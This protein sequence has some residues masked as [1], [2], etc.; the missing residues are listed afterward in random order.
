MENAKSLN[1]PI[2]PQPDD[3]TCG[4]T[5]LHAIYTFFKDSIS[6]D[7]VIRQTK[8]LDAG[9]TL[10]VFLACNA[11]QRGYNVTI[12]TYNLQLFDPT[13]FERKGTDLRH[14]LTEQSKVKSDP[15]LDLATGGYLEFL[16]LGGLLRYVDLTPRLLRR[17]LKQSIPILTGLSATYLYRSPRE[18][19]DCKYNDIAG[20]PVGHFVILAGY[21]KA[22]RLVTVVDPAT[23]NPIADEH[24]YQVSVDR[25]CGAIL[26]GALT[27]DANMVLIQPKSTKNK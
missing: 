26:L 14:K 11:L 20:D 18:T 9:G 16:K 7:D 15:K 24:Y 12:Y 25:I 3:T 4:P 21:D 2:L 17:L 19:P 5:C 23:Q 8:S 10:D 22:T 1:V 6:L 27:Y 13:W